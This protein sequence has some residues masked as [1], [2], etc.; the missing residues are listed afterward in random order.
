M[1]SKLPLAGCSVLVVDDDFYLAWDT[2]EVLE[3]AG[4]LVCG[5]YGNAA[6]ALYAIR[7]SVPLYAV[8][9]LNLGFG[10]DFQVARTLKKLAIPTILVTGYDS[11]IIP[12]DLQGIRCLQKPVGAGK[13]IAAVAELVI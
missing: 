9:D 5:P 13:L 4:A 10:P 7:E 1:S 6:E 11:S 2:T 3:E 12:A 8:V